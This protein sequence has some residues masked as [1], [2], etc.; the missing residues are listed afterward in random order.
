MP[1]TAVYGGEPFLKETLTQNFEKAKCVFNRLCDDKSREVFDCILKYKITGD[2]SYLKK[3]KTTP[4]E[5]YENILRPGKG[6][7]YI[8]LGA[9]NGDTVFY[10]FQR[11]PEDSQEYLIAAL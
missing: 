4:S 5:A 9:Y 7:T 6:E 11:V 3:C 10:F 1:D 2:I 8:D